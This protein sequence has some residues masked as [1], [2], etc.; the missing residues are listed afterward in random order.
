MKNSVRKNWMDSLKLMAEKPVII[1]PFIIIAFLESL[2]LEIIYFFPRHPLSILFNPIIRKYFGESYLHYPGNLF[3]VPN[4]YYYAE[5]AIY[6]FIGVALSAISINIFKNIKANIP[7]TTAALIKNVFKKYVSFILFGILIILLSVLIERVDRFIYTKIMRLIAEE[8]PNAVGKFYSTGLALFLY[9]SNIILQVFLV[10]T[11]PII[12]IEKKSL[13]KALG[14]SIYLGL[15]NFFGIFVLLLLPF[16]VYL[17]VVLLKSGLAAL[18]D[19]TFPEIVL[20]VTVTSIVI[21]IF[22]DC[23]MIICVSHFLW[24]NEKQS[25]VK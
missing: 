17:P 4:L 5:V 1:M 20:L 15:R 14:R 7:L 3:V 6:I 10:L 22:I 18:A 23:F 19:K 13:I 25:F 24:N 11:I 8:F 9:V 21:A 16:V 12:V 2:A